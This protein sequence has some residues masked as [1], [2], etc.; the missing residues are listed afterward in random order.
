MH[1]WGIH[2]Q[3]QWAVL[4]HVGPVPL[5]LQLSFLHVR[6]LHLLCLV[7]LAK[8]PVASCVGNLND[9]LVLVRHL[10]LLPEPGLPPLPVPL[11]LL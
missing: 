4:V 11:L 9:L 3:L 2:L 7:I 10:L 8:P 1:G 6:P 5:P